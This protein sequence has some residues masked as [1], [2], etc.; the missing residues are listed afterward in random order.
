MGT[1]HSSTKPSLRQR[2]Y[3]GPCQNMQLTLTSN[4]RRACVVCS[5]ALTVEMAQLRENGSFLLRGP[6]VQSFWTQGAAETVKVS[7]F[8]KLLF[9]QCFAYISLVRTFNLFNLK[10]HSHEQWQLYVRPTIVLQSTHPKH[11]LISTYQ[12]HTMP[13]LVCYSN[14]NCLHPIAYKMP[15]RIPV[16]LKRHVT[17]QRKWSHL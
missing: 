11:L 4:V 1:I 14:T 12:I 9:C 10:V 17:S 7:T 8:L 16:Q 3:L 5:C 15:K 6:Y 13:E 2:I